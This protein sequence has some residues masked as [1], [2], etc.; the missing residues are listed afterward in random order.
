MLREVDFRPM[1][2]WNPQAS[3]SY[4][5][6]LSTPPNLSMDQKK[7]TDFLPPNLCVCVSPNNNR[8]IGMSALWPCE[9]E[10]NPDQGTKLY[11]P[12]QMILIMSLAGANYG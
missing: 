2:I 10:E 12:H 11:T 6:K 5:S 8:E 7:T 1:R 3:G 9:Q 4:V